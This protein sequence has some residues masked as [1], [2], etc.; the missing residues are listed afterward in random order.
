MRKTLITLLMIAT[1]AIPFTG[2]KKDKDDKKDDKPI[3]LSDNSYAVDGV[4]IDGNQKEGAVYVKPLAELIL[5]SKNDESSISVAFKSRPT[6]SGT[7][8]IKGVK[9]A[10]DMGDKDVALGLYYVNDI[11]Y[12]SSSSMSEKAI[13]TID[14]NDKISV[15]IPKLILTAE[16]G[17]TVTFQAKLVEY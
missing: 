8:N 10:P 16:G 14:K 6:A 15:T 5:N 4:K 17:K 13:I 9:Q 12:F 2:C 11:Q 3:E 7:F 1:F